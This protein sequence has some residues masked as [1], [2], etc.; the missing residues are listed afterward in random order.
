MRSGKLTRKILLIE[1]DLQIQKFIVDYLKD[2]D[3]DCIAFSKPSDAL[4]E[5]KEND[6][7]LVILDLMLPEM[8][9]FEFI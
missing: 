6:F 1:D 3:F 2:Y 4:K 7:E 5:L 9:G 8:D